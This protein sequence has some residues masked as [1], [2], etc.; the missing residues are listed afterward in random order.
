MTDCLVRDCWVDGEWRLDLCRSFGPEEVR[1]WETLLHYLDEE[2]LT[3]SND[4]VLWALE[5]KGGYTS[6]SM[7]KFLSF[8]GV[9]NKRMQR[10]WECR[11]PMKIK[12]FMWLTLQDRLPTGVVLK[13]RNW[14][15]DLK[16]V[17]CRVPE[18]I[19]H[20]FFHCPL[21]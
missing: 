1:Q 17:I 9:I 10:I 20:I 5:K 6:Q 12:V 13:R 11:L 4:G 14:K 21:A 18:T 3:D 19:D 15:G 8:R 7:Y 2:N 16:C